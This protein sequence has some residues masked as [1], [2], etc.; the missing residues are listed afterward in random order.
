MALGKEK[1]AVSAEEE[2]SERERDGQ[3]EADT[4]RL[5]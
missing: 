4:W 3:T 1:L 2:E 5:R